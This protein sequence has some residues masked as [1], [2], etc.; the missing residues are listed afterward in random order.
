MSLL[1]D[2]IETMLSGGITEVPGLEIPKVTTL[3]W[4]KVVG[5]VVERQAAHFFKLSVTDED[6]KTG[7]IINCVSNGGDKFK[8]IF[9]DKEGQEFRSNLFNLLF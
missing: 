9:F 4:G 3:E 1:P 8:V 7:V 5:D 2:Y 6:L